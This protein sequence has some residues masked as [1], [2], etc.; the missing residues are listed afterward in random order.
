RAPVKR[1]PNRF[2]LALISSAASPGLSADVSDAL[3]T[4]T[5][6]TDAR[7][8][9][10]PVMLFSLAQVLSEAGR[11]LG[12]PSGGSRNRIHPRI[13]PKASGQDE[14]PLVKV[15]VL[16]RRQDVPAAAAHLPRGRSMRCSAICVGVKWGV[17]PSR[18]LKLLPGR[19][20][21]RT[22]ARLARFHPL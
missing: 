8:F 5:A 4:S 19:D 13:T 3:T 16:L 15:T 10:R 11:R 14:D 12:S 2:T 7:R 22:F 6:T 17:N 18:I 9:G 1:A 21:L 20:A